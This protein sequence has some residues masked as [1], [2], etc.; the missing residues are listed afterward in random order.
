MFANRRTGPRLYY[1][2]S[3]ICRLPRYLFVLIAFVPMVIVLTGHL[4]ARECSLNESCGEMWVAV[5]DVG[6]ETAFFDRDGETLKAPDV[7]IGNLLTA[8]R[9]INVRSR[10]A[11]WRNVVFTL[12][13]GQTV[14]VGDLRIVL[15]S[16]GR[17][18]IW[19]RIEAAP[20]TRIAQAPVD[21]SLELQNRVS[22]WRNRA[23]LCNLQGR[24]AARSEESFPTKE[25]P[26]EDRRIPVVLCNDG[27]MALFNGLLCAVG[28]SKG[29]D[30][31]Q[32]AQDRAP[33]GQWWRSPADKGIATLLLN[34]TSIRIKV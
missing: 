25:F 8:N 16:G 3:D 15:I 17:T 30:G 9:V 14:V 28:E 13:N 5:Q 10:P 4:S 29:C 33:G 32:N 23:L 20:E 12:N 11:D 31:V 2:A 1:A 18:Q 26:E 22:T 24:E 27:D 6:N 7:Q 21:K 34:Q 19:I